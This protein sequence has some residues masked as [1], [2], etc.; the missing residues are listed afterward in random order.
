[1]IF[2]DVSVLEL[3]PLREQV[4]SVA[5]QDLQTLL[6][7]GAQKATLELS[8]AKVPLLPHQGKSEP[9]QDL[10]SELSILRSLLLLSRETSL[11]V[12]DSQA[13]SLQLAVDQT[14]PMVE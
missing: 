2:P 9:V 10:S 6:H 14:L 12:A 1:M 11:F 7:S 8:S 5:V 13:G 4:V 3:P